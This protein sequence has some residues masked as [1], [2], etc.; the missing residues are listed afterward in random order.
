V[1]PLRRLRRRQVED[2]R[3]DVTGCVGPCY[4]TFVVF[5]VLVPRDIIV[6]YPFTLVYIYGPRVDE[7]SCHFLFLF[8]ISRVE[9]RQEKILVSIK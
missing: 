6:F 5:N 3:V 7:A 8:C 2:E 9:V 1:A 4:P